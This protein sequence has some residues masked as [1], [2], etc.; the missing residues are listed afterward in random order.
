MNVETPDGRFGEL[1][2]TISTN[3]SVIDYSMNALSLFVDSQGTTFILD[4]CSSSINNSSK[5]VFPG[6]RLPTRGDFGEVLGQEDGRVVVADERV[7]VSGF[8]GWSLVWR[9]VSPCKRTFDVRGNGKLELSIHTWDF[10][11]HIFQISMKSY[12]ENI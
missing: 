3:F 10:K 9:Y 7:N 12:M 5:M 8:T 4:V 11:N 1:I 6:D 2:S